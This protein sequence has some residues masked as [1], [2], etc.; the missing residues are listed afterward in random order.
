MHT[1]QP[2]DVITRDTDR[3]NFLSAQ[4]AKE[5]GLI[6][7]ILRRPSSNSETK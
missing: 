4:G 2:V 6:D 5:Y 1:G 3:D 7:E